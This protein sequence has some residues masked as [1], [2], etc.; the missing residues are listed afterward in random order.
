M[1]IWVVD[2]DIE[3]AV[4]VTGVFIEPQPN[5][6]GMRQ[7]IA[8]GGAPLGKYPSEFDAKLV[9]CKLFQ[10]IEHGER[11]FYMPE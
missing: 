10:A 3:R 2:Q 8:I 6:D 5:A 11:V 9:L 4:M 7:I 1:G